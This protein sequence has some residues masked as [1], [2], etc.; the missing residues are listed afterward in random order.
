MFSNIRYVPAIAVLVLVAAGTAQ[1]QTAE[2]ARPNA[3]A[4]AAPFSPASAGSQWIGWGADTTER[5]FQT[6]DRAGLTAAATPRLTLKWA[7]GFPNAQMAYGQPAVFGNRLFVGSADG[8]VYALDA[9][10]GCAH[11]TF[12]AGAPVRT[13][14]SVGPIGRAWAVYFGDLAG[15]AYAVDAATG[16]VVWKTRIDTHAAAK[17]TGAPTL[18]GGRLYVPA[19]SSEEGLAANGK[20]ACCT[21][22]GNLSAL[23]AVT[24]AVIWKTY[25]IPD[26]PKPTRLNKLGVQQTGPSGAAIWSSPTVDLDKGLVFVTTGDSYSEPVAATSD[27]FLAFDLKSGRI[28]WSRQVTSGDAFTVDCDFPD[29]LRVNCPA[30][31]GPDH[32]FGTSPMLVTLANGRRVLVAGQKSG[33][34][35]AIDPDRQGA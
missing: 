7:F 26:E 1:A 14:M 3:C 27:A 8:T 24:G 35:T 18:A 29:A 4:N 6:A 34:V 21:F 17:I 10:T 12:K 11:W 33:V 19:S 32:D 15:Y 28:L 25:T 5:R 2:A 23:D 16:A 30:P 13:A 9:A 20:Y 22:R 31:P